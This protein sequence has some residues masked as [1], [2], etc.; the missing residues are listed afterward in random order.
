MS[1][2][3]LPCVSLLN[4][5][6]FGLV[7]GQHERQVCWTGWSELNNIWVPVQSEGKHAG[8]VVFS[9]DAEWVSSG[10]SP[11]FNL[12]CVQG[13]HLPSKDSE[14]A[15]F[16]IFLNDW[17]DWISYLAEQFLPFV[18]LAL[19]NLPAHFARTVNTPLRQCFQS[20]SC[21][22]CTLGCDVFSNPCEPSKRHI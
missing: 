10:V 4:R 12:L 15:C 21:G 19:T 8:F 1:A 14:T 18:L 13:K 16:L 9:Q 11:C 20:S 22:A 17:L 7:L 2:I 6:V 3:Y 5:R